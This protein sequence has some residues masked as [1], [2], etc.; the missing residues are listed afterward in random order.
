MGVLKVGC[1]ESEGYNGCP[2]GEEQNECPEGG[3][4]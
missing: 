2:E 3:V 1:P 4:S